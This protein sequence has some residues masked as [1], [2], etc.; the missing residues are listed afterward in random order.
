MGTRFEI[1]GLLMAV[2]GLGHFVSVLPGRVVYISFGDNLLDQREWFSGF[3]DQFGIFTFKRG[4]VILPHN[5]I[6]LGV[7]TSGGRIMRIVSGAVAKD[8]NDQR[9]TVNDIKIHIDD[10][11][12]PWVTLTDGFASHR[13]TGSVTFL[14]D[15]EVFRYAS[16]MLRCAG[17]DIVGSQLF[18]NVPKAFNADVTKEEPGVIFDFRAPGAP[19]VSDAF[20]LDNPRSVQAND[21]MPYRQLTNAS[22]LGINARILLNSEKVPLFIR[23]LAGAVLFPRAF[24]RGVSYLRDVLSKDL[25]D[26]D[27][28]SSYFSAAQA[29]NV[30]VRPFE[31][32]A[33][34]AGVMHAKLLAVDGRVLSVGAPFEQGYVDTHDHRIDAW[35]RGASDGLPKHDAG[36]AV[37]GEIAQEMYETM[38]LLWD[39]AVPTDPLPGRQ[40]TSP[41]R[42]PLPAPITVLDDADHGLCDM[43]VVRTLTR[44]RFPTIDGAD[45][46]EG[47]KGILEAYQR[48]I[49]SATDFVYLETQYFTSDAIGNAIVARM[50]EVPTLQVIVLL[51]IAPDVVFYPFKQRRLITR[52]RREIDQKGQ[53]PQRFGVFTRWTHEVGPPRPRLAPVYIHSKVGIV[54]NTWATIGSANLDGFSLDGS[55][56]SDWLR[57]LRNLFSNSGSSRFEQRAIEVNGVLRDFSNTHVV[58][59]VRRKLWGEH[60]GFV[61]PGEGEPVITAP[62]L[63]RRP[64]GP[65]TPPDED[66]PPF[67]PPDPANPADPLGGWLKLWYDRAGAT[68]RQLKSDPSKPLTSMA[69]VLPWPED[70]TTHKTPRDYLTALGIQS[71][72]VVPIKG[73]R[74]FDLKKGDW[75]AGSKAAMDY[76]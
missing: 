36:F 56:P 10:A 50:L 57:R 13:G 20:D 26:V 69:T 38:K 48:G 63:Q 52:I 16:A 65:P 70:N 74:K 3:T 37:T 76:D 41:N 67:V 24:T 4:P 75:K 8:T 33:L 18:F 54:D 14:Q 32:D 23:I 34:R 49:E 61:V 58:D 51:N 19:N 71:H 66:D 40:P 59:L 73:T 28:C 53:T 55:Y 2:D 7:R 17:T 64:S 30:T 47:E 6:H 60:L 15:H 21:G 11:V 39:T 12:G 22:N 42:A 43:Q 9:L 68:L 27:E 35:V 5:D 1:H 44:N 62:E 46:T 45:G 29:S 31:Q 25:T 72:A